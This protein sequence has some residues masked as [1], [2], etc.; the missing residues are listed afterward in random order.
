MG[1][2]ACPDEPLGWDTADI[3]AI[4]AHKMAFNKRDLCP[5]SRRPGGCDQPCGA[6][7]DHHKIIARG[8]LGV[9]PGSRMDI[10]DEGLIMD[11]LRKN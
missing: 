4:A 8:R 10:V 11:V 6:C 7:P 3:K 9:F 5:Q 2:A 1:G